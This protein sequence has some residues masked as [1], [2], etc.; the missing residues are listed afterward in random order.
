MI[1]FSSISKSTILVFSCFLTSQGY[2]ISFS[3]RMIFSIPLPHRKNLFSEV[4]PPRVLEKPLTFAN[5]TPPK[6]KIRGSTITQPLEF[7]NRRK[8]TVPINKVLHFLLTPQ[9]NL[10]LHKLLLSFMLGL[11][12]EVHNNSSDLNY[13]YFIV[14]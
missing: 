11:F 1:Q 13:K 6:S 4:N 2:E 7:L 9:S 3:L 8:I 5:L 14:K 10:F 12:I